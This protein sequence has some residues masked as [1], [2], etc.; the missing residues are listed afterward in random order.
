M[1]QNAPK[2]S[3]LRFANNSNN[4]PHPQYEGPYEGRKRH[5]K[6]KKAGR[7]AKHVLHDILAMTGWF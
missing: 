6:R 5:I 1:D 2:Q 7:I 3:G 4:T